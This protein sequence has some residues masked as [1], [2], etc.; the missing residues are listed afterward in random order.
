M[1][2][3]ESISHHFHAT[4]SKMHNFEDL[5]ANYTDFEFQHPFDGFPE[6]DHDHN[7]NHNHDHNYNHNHDHNYNSNTN[8]ASAS[9]SS[10]SH[11]QAEKRRRDRINAQLSRL[12]RLIP[13]SD[14]MDKAALLERVVEQV[15]ELKRQTSEISK[16]LIVPT[17]SDDITIECQTNNIQQGDHHHHHHHDHHDDH[18]NDLMMIKATFCCEDRP[19]LIPEIIKA[20]KDLN[21]TIIGAE[22]ATLGG[23][24]KSILLLYYKLD[25]NLHPDF[26]FSAIKNSLMGVLTRLT[27]WPTSS[28]SN[29]RVT[30]KRQRFFFSS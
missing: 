24:L 5:P 15:K 11:R 8:P 12:R 2:E 18:S 14:K 13:K 21:L 10:Q 22:I 6:I 1:P 19:D 23:R 9:A 26:N 28:N 16:L 3:E 17:E 4:A 25:T 20:L 30:S 29:F 27:S 7:H